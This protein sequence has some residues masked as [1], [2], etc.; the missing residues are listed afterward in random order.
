MVNNH[1]LIYRLLRGHGNFQS[2][3]TPVRRRLHLVKAHIM[4][5][6]S[7]F[8]DILGVSST[9]NDAELKSAYRKL[10]LKYHPDKNP[11]AGDKFKEISHAY[12]V[13][14]NPDKRA[15]YDRYGED[16]LNGDAG[17]MNPEDLFS[18]FF[19]SGFFG[20]GG[21]SRQRGPRRGEDVT[22]N[23]SVTL[24]EIYTGKTAK[25]AIQR[26]IICSGCQGKGGKD[27][28]K[29]T[30]C[31]GTGV[32]MT[33]RQMG[34]MIQQMQSV[35][36]ECQGEGEVVKPADRC[37]TCS[38]KKVTKEKKVIEIKVE[39]GSVNGQRIKFSG[40][41]DEAPGIVPGDVVVVITEKE[42]PVFKRQGAD[43]HVKVKIDLV[44]ALAGGSFTIN[45]L[46]GRILEGKIQPG[47]VIKPEE[48][49]VIESEGLPEKDKIY[50]KGHMYVHFEIIFP[51]TNWASVDKIKK[52]EE[53]LPPKSQ[54]D[55]DGPEKEEVELSK[56]DNTHKSRNQKQQQKHAQHG[57]HGY[58][59]ED[60][61]EDMHHGNAG[62]SCAQ[63]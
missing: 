30:G 53:I 28:K 45:H 32:R 19:G 17:G 22:F 47:E 7:K 39:P 25:I 6:D 12:E 18:Q 31:K 15:A 54:M 21:H 1:A 33:I 13:L 23:L 8:Y 55:L 3:V 35:C 26:N 24:E 57:H 11:D 34:P 63:Q 43:L 44:T 5:R 10:A 61:E 29:C 50:L 37:P 20:G 38:G 48:I 4:V 51:Q 40:E 2:S 42:H 62:V 16:G 49:R 14:S 60:D 36:N 56:Y 41:A 52:L 59:E 46:D 27:V 9:A 58:Y